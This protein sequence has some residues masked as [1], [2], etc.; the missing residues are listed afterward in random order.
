MRNWKFNHINFS[1]YP[2]YDGEDLGVFYSEG[3][4]SV[5]IWAPTANSVEFRIYN[6]STSGNATLVENLIPAV[7]G[8][9]QLVLNGNF[10]NLYYTL[11]VDDGEALNEVPDIY[12]R[13][14][15]TNGRRGLIFDPEETNPK[16]WETDVPI[17]G[18]NPVDAI[19]Y[20]LHV[21][22]FSIDP[23]SGFK[24]K[25][26][27]LA[28]TE[29][30][31]TN[32]SGEK[33]GIDHLKELAITHVHLLPVND[34]YSVDEAD[35]AKQYNWGY[36]PQNFNA[37]E[38]SYSNNPDTT[39]RI[40][41]LK[42]LIQALHRNGIGVIFDVVYN[43]TGYTRRSVFNQTIP[44]YFYRQNRAGGFADASGCGNEIASERAMVR[45]YIVDSLCYWTK[46]YHADGFR[47]DLMG[48][49]D[50]ETMNQIRTKLDQIN[51]AIVLY[52]EGWTADKSPLDEKYRAVKNNVA[53]LKRIAVFATR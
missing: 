1:V 15:G 42:Q 8:T 3:Q 13:A 53:Q 7:N 32:A 34:F 39:S 9:W 29:E 46:E 27:F 4:L 52:G 35:A 40:K 23:A 47:F 18:E 2:F 36:D 11:K 14:V 38:G 37:P 20:E 26:R 24:N 19:I 44:G 17:P 30:G 49:L 45:K 21:R 48:I 12:A 50:I 5:K 10:K 16:D 25:G 51:P 22:D 43:H 33:I 28:F 41:E 31:L 6:N